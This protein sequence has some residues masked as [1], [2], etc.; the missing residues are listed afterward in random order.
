MQ[1]VSADE[2]VGAVADGFAAR[3]V[4]ERAPQMQRY[5]RNIA[6]FLGVATTDRRAVVTDVLRHVGTPESI[7]AV[8]AALYQRQEREFHY[9][10]WDLCT[11]PTVLRALTIHDVRWLTPFIGCVPWWDTVD[12]LVPRVIGWIFKRAP[13]HLESQCK[14]WIEMDN[15]WYQRAA[16]IVQLGWKE[17]TQF[18]LL[19]EL[20]VRRAN[21]KEFF[22]RKGAGWALREYSKTNPVAVR[23]FLDAHPEL[24]SLT[25]REAGK[26]C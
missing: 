13:Q 21:S 16:I 18:E 6:P 17:H 2:F 26:Y 8:C 11:R 1:S 12:Y 15:T 20:V 25:L 4:A 9:A 22:V 5:M 10:A 14:T 19:A 23:R 3:A 24:N 7:E